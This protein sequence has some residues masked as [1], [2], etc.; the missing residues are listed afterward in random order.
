MILL[1]G[2]IK[3]TNNSVAIKLEESGA[4]RQCLTQA[5]VVLLTLSWACTLHC[6]HTQTVFTNTSGLVNTGP[7][8][9]GYLQ[10]HFTEEKLKIWTQQHRPSLTGLYW[11]DTSATH[12]S[13]ICR[14]EGLSRSQ[15]P[16]QCWAWPNIPNEHSLVILTTGAERTA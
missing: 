9:V 6:T 4:G 15:G 1:S 14:L 5:A 11:G 7:C 3:H 16:H 13:W 2:I 12:G 10:W 8:E